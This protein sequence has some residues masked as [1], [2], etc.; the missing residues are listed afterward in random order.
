MRGAQFLDRL[1]EFGAA[2]LEMAQLRQHHFLVEDE[3]VILFV[4]PGIGVEQIGDFGQ[5]E[6]EVLAL[7]NH[8]Q[9]DFLPAVI[10][11]GAAASNWV[12][13]AALFV[14]AQ[15]S[16]GDAVKAGDFADCKWFGCAVFRFEGG[17][18]E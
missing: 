6:A 4:T 16:Q 18:F 7:E 12:Q 1:V 9:A 2:F 15:G 8:L 11:P 17:G 3:I 10:E 5:G 14:K 13:Q